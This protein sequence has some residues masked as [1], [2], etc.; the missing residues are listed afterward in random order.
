MG[1]S[2]KF[3]ALMPHTVVISTLVG[4]STDGYATATYTT[5]ST[6]IAR[7]RGTHEQVRNFEGTEELARSV[8]WIKSTSTFNPS[9]TLITLP[10][11][12]TPGTLLNIEAYPDQD[13][14]HHLKAFF[15]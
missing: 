14:L 10:N 5:G 6:H 9:Q 8:A 13:G 3:E 4:L 15:A 1:F 11:S 7:V 2:T 12:E